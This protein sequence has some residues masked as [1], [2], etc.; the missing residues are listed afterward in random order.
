V[1]FRQQWC[2][3]FNKSTRHHRGNV[4]QAVKGAQ[5]RSCPRGEAQPLANPVEHASV[6]AFK[7]RDAT[8]Q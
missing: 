8:T 1:Q 3:D 7:K 5:Q 4:A 2:Q 6:Q